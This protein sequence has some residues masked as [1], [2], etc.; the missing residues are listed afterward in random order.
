MTHLP[1]NG[2]VR[3]GIKQFHLSRW[4]KNKRRETPFKGD[5]V[6]A[7]I[8]TSNCEKLVPYFS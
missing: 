2:D 1:D 5:K 8:K 6:K 3:E 7:L 4:F